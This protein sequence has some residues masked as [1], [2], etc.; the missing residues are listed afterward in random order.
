[1]LPTAWFSAQRHVA[2]SALL[3]PHGNPMLRRASSEPRRIHLRKY[4]LA[5]EIEAIRHLS[6]AL[7]RSILAGLALAGDDG[8]VKVKSSYSMGETIERLKKD[9]A[10]KS[11]E[12]GTHVTREWNPC[13]NICPANERL[14]PAPRL[15]R[16]VVLSNACHCFR[17]RLAP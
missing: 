7:T 10:D 2:R 11:I 17:R 4:R 12:P 3:S 9:I 16:V 8:I 5:I 1:M 15:A 6:S 14:L 13:K